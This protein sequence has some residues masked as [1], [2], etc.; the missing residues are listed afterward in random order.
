MC[1]ICSTQIERENVERERGDEDEG[2]EGAVWAL[3]LFRLAFSRFVFIL[4][5]IKNN[6]NNYFNY[7][8]YFFIFYLSFDFCGGS[9]FF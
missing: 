6:R 5:Q 1:E 2:E 3:Y 7:Y 4:I 9:C 8:C